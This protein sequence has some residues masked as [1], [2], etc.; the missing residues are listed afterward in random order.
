MRVVLD[1]NTVVSGLLWY[2]NP[3]RVLDAA[4]RGEIQVFTSKAL[5]DELDEVLSRD[6]FAVRMAHASVT[7]ETLFLGYTALASTVEPVQIPSVIRKD[8][9][10]NAVLAY[11]AAAGAQAIVSGDRHLLSLGVFAGIPILTSAEFL[12]Q[13]LPGQ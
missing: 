6:K 2:G 8:P 5:L 10:D 9:D 7:R 1:T 3:R 12:L 13:Y 11:A 4:Q